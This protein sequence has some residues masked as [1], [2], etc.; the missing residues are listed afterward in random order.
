MSAATDE[1]WDSMIAGSDEL[2]DELGLAK[3][4]FTPRSL[5]A[6]DRWLTSLGN[7]P[8]DE[9]TAVRLGLYLAR[10]LTETHDG[11]LVRIHHK[12]HALDGEWAVTG[13][14]RDLANDYHVPF[15]V[16]AARIAFDRSL[17]ARRWYDELLR[18]GRPAG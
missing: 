8:L 16:S 10:L 7:D 12:S 15:M 4:R 9:E 13:F 5:A 1:M 18:E 2:A 14:A 17:T 6:I 3:E 11:G